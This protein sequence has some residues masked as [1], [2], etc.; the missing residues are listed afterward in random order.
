M[1][2]SDLDNVLP[3]DCLV[4]AQIRAEWADHT[5]YYDH[6]YVR[7]YNNSGKGL[8]REH[9]YV[10]LAAYGIPDGFHV[11]H[12]D[13]NR[14]NNRADNLAVLSASEHHRLH[15][16]KRRIK[17]KCLVCQNEFEA[18]KCRVERKGTR[19]CS[20]ACRSFATR[21]VEHPSAEYLAELLR[22]IGNWTVLGRMFGVT[23]KAVRKWAI[24]YNLDLSV[25]D[26]RLKR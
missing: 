26:G 14:L 3:L 6:G 4:V 22:S 23:D 13:R 19:Y 8:L 7:Y 18:I 24:G 16:P 17:M 5:F 12:I 25:C 10:A 1:F 9:Q 11:H 21:K 20:D 15:N 2:V